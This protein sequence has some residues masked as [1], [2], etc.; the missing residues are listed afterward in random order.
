MLFVNL[1]YVVYWQSLLFPRHA[2]KTNCALSGQYLSKWSLVFRPLRRNQ[3][4]ADFRNLPQLCT[5]TKC[6]CKARLKCR[7]I[8]AT[9]CLSRGVEPYPRQSTVLCGRFVTALRRVFVIECS[10][11][12]RLF[13]STATRHVA[14]IPAGVSRQLT[15]SVVQSPS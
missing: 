3:T 14:G 10:V 4:H 1:L 8:H 12:L 7:N 11:A 6:S 15:Y 13:S 2:G 9:Y 5:F